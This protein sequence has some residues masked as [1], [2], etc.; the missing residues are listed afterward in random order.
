MLGTGRRANPEGFSSPPG[1]SRT[2]QLEPG[3]PPIY[4]YIY[5]EREREREGEGERERERGKETERE[6]YICKH[7]IYKTIH[8]YL[9]YTFMVWGGSQQWKILGG[10][11]EVLIRQY[12]KDCFLFFVC[13]FQMFS[14]PK[15][16]P[17]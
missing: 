4:I 16:F 14:R 12:N 15:G 11:T 1:A 10:F 17:K 3:G 8:I 2:W 9:T 13:Y 6:I 7:N 5:I